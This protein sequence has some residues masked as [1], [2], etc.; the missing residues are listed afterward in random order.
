MHLKTNM[1]DPNGEQTQ[2]AGALH[3]G[4]R[5][6][7]SDSKIDQNGLKTK[8]IDLAEVA[9]PNLGYRSVQKSSPPADTRQDAAFDALVLSV[10]K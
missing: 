2:K 3:Q 9:L 10:T 5:S 8:S 7:P 6:Q 4:Q 1:A